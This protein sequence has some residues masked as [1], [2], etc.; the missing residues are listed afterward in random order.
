MNLT[1]LLSIDKWIE[2]EKE[3]NKISGMNA[4][5]FDVEGMRITDFTKWANDLCRAIRSTDKGR[6]FICSVAQ[7]HLA[8]K[9]KRTRLPV[10]EECDAGLMKLVVPIFKGDEFPGA[11]SAC[12]LL[13][14]NGEVDVFAVTKITGMNEDKVKKLSEGIGFV[15]KDD[16]PRIEKLIQE[17]IACIQT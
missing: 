3:I 4:S 2:L 1:N 6:S 7:K 11:A 5:V 16:I 8:Q 13:P 10:V 9:A 17:R 14:E 15:T 12:G